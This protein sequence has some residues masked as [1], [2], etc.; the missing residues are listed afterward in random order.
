MS[1]VDD[2]KYHDLDDMDGLDGLDHLDDTNPDVNDEID[3]ALGDELDFEDDLSRGGDPDLDPF[4]DPDHVSVDAEN[5]SEAH[6]GPTPGSSAGGGAGSGNGAHN[7]FQVDDEPEANGLGLGKMAFLGIGGLL[8]LATLYFVLKATGMFGDANPDQVEAFRQQPQSPGLQSGSGPQ[9][10]AMPA[11]RPQ[12]APRI[13]P[14][15]PDFAATKLEPQRSQ[16]A[17]SSPISKEALK[18]LHSELEA[19]IS[20]NAGEV[21][22]VVRSESEQTREVIRGL[23][24][25]MPVSDGSLGQ[26]ISQLDDRTFRLEGILAEIERKIDATAA[27]SNGREELDVSALAAQ[28]AASLPER[29][30]P[31]SPYVADDTY[32]GRTRLPGFEVIKTTADGSMSVVKTPSDKVNVYFDGEQFY[33]GG[34]LKKVS[35]IEESGWVVLVEDSFF[36]DAEREP[37]E[38]KVIVKEV[39]TKQRKKEITST[40]A[41]NVKDQDSDVA[42]SKERS[43]A[44]VSP[45]PAPARPEPVSK[46][47]GWAL[48]VV[49]QEAQSFLLRGPDLDWHVAKAGRDFKDFGVVHGYEEGKGLLVGDAVIPTYGE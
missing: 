26:V 37:I 17:A 5:R 13:E 9:R 12:S 41:P 39:P 8:F 45:A 28:L 18:D 19:A 46:T 1:D 47:E 24:S 48:H 43:D 30:G 25:K 42:D 33:H 23:S 34:S 29:Q 32:Q 44:K 49:D 27:S 11:E 2:Q 6:D 38:P 16:S 3:D 22:E 10:Q 21:S 40:A 7:D 15:E 4:E 14:D 31:A 35:G 36:I 20:G